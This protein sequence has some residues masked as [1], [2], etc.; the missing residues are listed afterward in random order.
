MFDIKN[1]RNVILSYLAAFIAAAVIYG[2]IQ[3]SGMS[4][5]SVREEGA[6]LPLV[7]V[8]S[9]GSL[10]N[11]MHGY[12]EGVDAGYF[13]SSLTPVDD[14]MIVNLMIDEQSL[15]VSAARYEVYNDQDTLLLEEGDCTDL[16]KE[17]TGRSCRISFQ[18]QMRS[19]CEYCLHI[20]LTAGSGQDLF[21][22]TRLRYGSDLKAAEKLKFVLDFNEETFSKDSIPALENYLES[23]GTSL[24]SDL[25]YV[26]ISSSPESVTWGQ[27]APSRTSRVFPCLKEIN[28]ETAS[29]TLFYSIESQASDTTSVYMVSEYYRIRIGDDKIYLLD[30]QRS[31]EEDIDLSEAV[32]RE[33]RIH[34]GCGDGS[35]R[36]LVNY[37][38]E[39]QQ[40]SYICSDH[41]LWVYHLT[42][43]I[44]TMVYEERGQEH[45]CSLSEDTALK[46]IHADPDTGDLYFAVYG[47]MH[48]GRY[49]G[50]EGV[51]AC[52]FSYQEICI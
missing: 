3:N 25:S 27:L 26:D 5:G 9:G 42:D 47:Y 35:S 45:G 24:Q 40:F 1:Y 28:T 2:I 20:I 17:G 49:E 32:V 15:P 44:L 48:T 39:S 18:S 13:R 34:L 37:G 50:R 23:T 43:S 33:G 19:N 52:H 16:K 11:E 14:S 41:Q 22:Y 51:L 36:Q 29:F 46:V 31:M 21:Y 30:F 12:T 8:Q 6:T 7:Y 10:I 38:N 4:G